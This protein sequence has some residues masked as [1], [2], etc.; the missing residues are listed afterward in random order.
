[1]PRDLPAG[2]LPDWIALNF[3]PSLGPVRI[4]RALEAGYSP[5]N[6]GTRARTL[7]SG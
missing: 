2:D 3:L 6:P 1:M 5:G 4:S 7:R